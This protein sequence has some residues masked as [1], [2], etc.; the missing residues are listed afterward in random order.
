LACSFEPANIAVTARTMV[1]GLRGTL[2][3]VF[4]IGMKTR[5]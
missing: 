3:L 2:V 5:W 4:F 1:E